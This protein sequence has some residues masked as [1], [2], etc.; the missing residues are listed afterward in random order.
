[1]EIPGENLSI[2][3]I[4]EKIKKKEGKIV[5]KGANFF[6]KAIDHLKRNF[7]KIQKYVGGKKRK[8]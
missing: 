8:I 4:F 5:G 3:E 7:I 2:E 1:L 6:E